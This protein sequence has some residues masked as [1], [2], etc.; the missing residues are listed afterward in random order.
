LKVQ[1]EHMSNPRY[2][3]RVSPK[4]GA[5]PSLSSE[6]LDALA[7]LYQSLGGPDWHI[8]DGWMSATNPCGGGGT[9]GDAWYGVDCTLFESAALNM[10]S[11]HVT[12]LALPQNNLIG[13][14]PS[15]HSLQDLLLLDLSNPDSSEVFEFQNSVSGTLDAIC[16]LANLSTVVLTD[17]NLSGPIPDC[18]QGLESVVAFGLDYNTI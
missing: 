13:E 3:N 12:G 11:L 6:E 4:G 9:G 7:T 2:P 14:L 18:I 1:P 10:S 8:R 5:S 15:L 16:G 17:N